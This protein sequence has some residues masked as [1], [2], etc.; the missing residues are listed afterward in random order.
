MSPSFRQ[1]ISLNVEKTEQRLNDL[2]SQPQPDPR[3]IEG[4][5]RELEVLKRKLSALP[6]DISPQPEEALTH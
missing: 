4:E 2:Q 5:R 1:Q 3:I 6:I